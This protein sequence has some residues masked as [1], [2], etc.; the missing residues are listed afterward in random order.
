MLSVLS[1]HRIGFVASQW[2]RMNDG[3]CGSPRDEN[4]SHYKGSPQVSSYL[5]SCRDRYVGWSP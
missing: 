2:A 5:E 4:G 1:S 3:R